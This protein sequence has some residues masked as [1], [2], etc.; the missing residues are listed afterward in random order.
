MNEVQ[1]SITYYFRDA[2]VSQRTKQVEITEESIKITF[3]MLTAGKIDSSTCR[4][5]FKAKEKRYVA[6]AEN[7]DADIEE[8]KESKQIKI[9]LALQVVNIEP[10]GGVKHESHVSDL[11]GT[12]FLPA[13]LSDSGFLTPETDN[14]PW[15][16]RDHLSPV[17][18][19]VLIVGQVQAVDQYIATQAKELSDI[20]NTRNWEQ[21][22]S[23]AKGLWLA[24]NGTELLG[25]FI[26]NYV[27]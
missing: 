6:V 3:D 26:Y 19:D 11:T 2:V 1:K 22:I 7:L 18:D 13:S 14:I 20:K 9:I 25:K 27:Q 4:H 10:E 23:F 21:Y 24:V 16:P 15:I 5:L 17:V 12:L 8:E